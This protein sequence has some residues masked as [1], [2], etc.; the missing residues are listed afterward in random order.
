MLGKHFRAFSQPCHKRA[1]R[2]PSCS[3][4]ACAPQAYWVRRRPRTGCRNAVS[5]LA[6]DELRSARAQEPLLTTATC[7]AGQRI[8]R[9]S[10]CPAK[11]AGALRAGAALRAHKSALVCICCRCSAR[12]W[13][14][15]LLY[16]A[17]AAALCKL[18]ARPSGGRRCRA[19]RRTR[20]P[21]L[22]A[23][24][25]EA[26]V[27]AARKPGPAAHAAVSMRQTTSACAGAWPAAASKGARTAEDGLD[28]L[29]PFSP[30]NMRAD[31]ARS[32]VRREARQRL[33]EHRERYAAL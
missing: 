12:S 1:R 4:A 14:P 32:Q 13:A 8:W 27:L 25:A 15:Y 7:R 28:V 21:T 18:T 29:P 6:A 3:R 9:P 10:C 24:P 2:Y 23:V 33:G 22:V 30:L 20:T 26:G 31:A 11:P 19:T 17:R 5:L 16:R